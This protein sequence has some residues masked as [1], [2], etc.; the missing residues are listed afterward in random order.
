[1][2][3][4]VQKQGLTYFEKFSGEESRWSDGI[5]KLG[6][7]LRSR[8]EAWAKILDA[9]NDHKQPILNNV[10]IARLGGDVVVEMKAV[11]GDLWMV[12]AHVCSNKALTI[13]RPCHRLDLRVGNMEEIV[14]RIRAT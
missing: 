6:A 8:D 9:A 1:M 7:D 2:V 10:N 14:A 3:A 13:I 4:R 12:L 5:F 11:S